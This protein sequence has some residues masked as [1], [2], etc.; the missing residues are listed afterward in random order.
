MAC[1][2]QQTCRWL[3]ILKNRAW[4]ADCF[5][6]KPFDAISWRQIATLS[7]SHEYFVSQTFLFRRV[8]CITTSVITDYHPGIKGG[9]SLRQVSSFYGPG[10][11][12]GTSTVFVSYAYPGIND[13][14]WGYWLS[15]EFF[16]MRMRAF[17][18]YMGVLTVLRT[19][20]PLNAMLVIY[21]LTSGLRALHQSEGKYVAAITV[22]RRLPVALIQSRLT[23]R[24]Y[25]Y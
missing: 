14:R 11:K 1:I 7:T 13:R 2:S 8:P 18:P 23:A 3:F 25:G 5:P 10:C 19:P 21:S 22:F 6:G 9:C 4:N 15:H 24:G 20:T 16:N 17:I 12:R